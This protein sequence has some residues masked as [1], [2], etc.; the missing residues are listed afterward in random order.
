M[1]TPVSHE[2]HRQR[3]KNRFLQNGLDSFEK[4]NI[5]ELLLFYSIPQKDT[6]D[7]AHT[8]LDNFGTLKGVFEADFSELIKIPGIK[9][10][11][12]TLIK[13]IPEL[14]RE[15][16][17][18]EIAEERV[19]DTADKIGK[20]FVNKYIGEVNEVVY[21]MLLDNG[22]KLLNVTKI[23][24]GSVSSA[25]VSPRKIMNQVIKYNASMAVVAHNHPNGLAVPSMEDVNTTYSLRMILENYEVKLIEHILV[26]GN[27][28][29]PIIHETH[30]TDMKYEEHQK[31]FRKVDLSSLK[32]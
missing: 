9:E 8:L 21:L 22:F 19:F 17:F 12:A 11:T 31:L 24:E 13:L 28:Y 5:L 14:A 1:K 15:Y 32:K 16:M 26:G 30:S 7:L 4:H 2:G 20:F 10:N 27:E 18:E 6:N 25:R 3:L 23:H 29:F